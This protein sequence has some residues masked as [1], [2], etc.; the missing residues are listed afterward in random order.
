MSLVEEPADAA[1]PPLDGQAELT[2]GMPA[3]TLASVMLPPATALPVIPS[4]QEGLTPKERAFTDAWI[5]AGFNSAAAARSLNLSPKAGARLRNSPRVVAA[6]AESLERN[7]LGKQIVLERIAAVV[8]AEMRDVAEWKDGKVTFRDSADIGADGHA[9]ISSLKVDENG[10]IERV[11]LA[12][13]NAVLGLLSRILKLVGPDAA[14]SV[15]V[16]IQVVIS[17]EDAQVL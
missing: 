3:P 12:D 10:R 5:I 4:Y 14:V 9:A 13:K 16:P 7:S 2:A 6:L 11:Q 17:A 1:L 15:A 8:R